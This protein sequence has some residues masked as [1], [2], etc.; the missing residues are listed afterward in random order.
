VTPSVQRLGDE[1]GIALILALMVLLTLSGLALA[2]LASSALEPRISRNFHDASRARWLAEAGIE[3]GYGLL[4]ADGDGTWNTLRATADA[5]WVALP[6]LDGA[7]LPGLTP[8][9]GTYA[10]SIRNDRQATDSMTVRSAGTFNTTTRT[11]EVVVRR[12]AEGSSSEPTRRVF[13]TISG[14][15]EF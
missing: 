1:R 13:Y 4:A 14:W 7:A 6:S 12:V 5:S 9:E 15:R 10:V 2:L 3:L 8:A 11:I